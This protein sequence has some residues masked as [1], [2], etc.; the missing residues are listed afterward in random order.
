MLFSMLS[1]NGQSGADWEAF[2]RANGIDPSYTYNAWVVAGMPRRNGGGGGGGGYSGPSAAQIAAQQAAAEKARQEQTQRDADAKAAA[3]KAAADKAA[4]DAEA[5]RQFQLHKNAALSEMKGI[6]GSL[7]DS[8]SGTGLKGLDDSP[9]VSGLKDAPNDSSLKG[10][11][12]QPATPAPMVVTDSRVVDAQGVP[13]GLPKSVDDAILS[14]YANAPA[15]VS[16]RVRKGF[17]AIQTR[18]WKVARAWFQ[19]AQNH[20]PGNPNLQ[21]LAELADYT[22]KRIEKGGKPAV[23]G[24]APPSG[25]VTQKQETSLPL[26]T[27][28]DFKILFPGL[29]SNPNAP[30]TMPTDADFKAVFG[31][32]KAEN[33]YLLEQAI[34]MTENDPVLIRLSR[35]HGSPSKN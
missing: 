1:A 13:S 3:E 11:D 14:D 4:A 16:D 2:K 19:D 23:S 6:A 28:E 20:D 31:P 27:D 17:Q 12:P 29:L 34:K 24:I 18:D 32:A 21:R 25:L 33:A 22:Q 5:A 30:A 9:T 15:G 26:P 10:L 7:D 35:P 8:G